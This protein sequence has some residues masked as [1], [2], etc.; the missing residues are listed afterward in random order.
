M[1]P[2]SLRWLVTQGR[3]EAAHGILMKYAEKSSVVVDSAT[4]TSML[5]GCRAVETSATSTQIERSPLDLV[6]TVR[7]RKRTVI[8]CYNWYADYFF[9]YRHAHFQGCPR[10][11]EKRELQ[12]FYNSDCV[13]V[14]NRC[15][16]CRV[17]TRIGNF[18]K[19][20]LYIPVYSLAREIPCSIAQY[21]EGPGNEIASGS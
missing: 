20:L 7:M 10:K 3:I 9:L 11:F 13:V 2:E 8:L 21:R 6:R 14:I 12:W 15:I 17:N 16:A 19:H 1:F 4:L 5:E 18:R